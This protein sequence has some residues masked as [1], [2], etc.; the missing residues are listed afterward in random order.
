MIERN[1]LGYNTTVC[2]DVNVT[3]TFTSKMVP[4]T[5]PKWSPFFKT[6]TTKNTTFHVKLVRVTLWWHYQCKIALKVYIMNNSSKIILN[7]YLKSKM[8]PKMILVSKMTTIILFF[9]FKTGLDL[10]TLKWN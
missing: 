2:P 1:I 3:H 10:Y 7:A 4:T 8:V 9:R 5:D 6:K